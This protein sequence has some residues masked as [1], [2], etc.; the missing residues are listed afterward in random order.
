MRAV[1]Y[2]GI[3]NTYRHFIDAGLQWRLESILNQE[4]FALWNTYVQQIWKAP[5]CLQRQLIA[6]SINTARELLLGH[7]ENEVREKAL[8]L[9]E[10]WEGANKDATVWLSS[11]C[12]QS[13]HSVKSHGYTSTRAPGSCN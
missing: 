6:W 4:E 5:T 2:A 3:K 13:G 8:E 11:S 10:E 12:L 7:G 9:L 1:T